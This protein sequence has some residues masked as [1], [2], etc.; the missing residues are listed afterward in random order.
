MEKSLVGLW[1]ES[2][3]SSFNALINRKS[4]PNYTTDTIPQTIVV[5]MFNQYPSLGARE[6]GTAYTAPLSRARFSRIAHSTNDADWIDIAESDFWFDNYVGSKKVV[7]ASSDVYD[8]TVADGSPNMIVNGV[9][10]HNC[11]KK[12]KDVMAEMKD[13][14]INGASP[15]VE[16]G[17]ITTS[18]VEEIWMLIE[19]F[20]GYGFN[21][22]H[23][24]SYSAITCVELWMKYHYPVEYLT[25]LLNNTK[26]GKKK[27]NSKDDLLAVYINYARKRNIDVMGPSINRSSVEFATDGQIILFSLRHVKN[28]AKAADIIASGQP[29][30]DV[31]DFYERAAATGTSAKTGK[32]TVRKVNKEVVDSLISAGAFRDFGDRN[33]VSQQYYACRKKKGEVAPQFPESEWNKMEEEML[34]ICLS[35]VPL[36]RRF[37]KDIAEKK[38]CPIDEADERKRTKVFGRITSIVPR[39]SK[40][41]NQMYVVGLTDD[42]DNMTFF[43]FGG[44]MV[45]FKDNFKVGYVA[46]I[47][48]NRFED[49][50]TRYYDVD[51]DADI[52][53][54]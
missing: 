30:K 53:E 32:T 44:A 27:F 6:S 21:A 10:V 7:S 34:G 4:T 48:L 5:K 23:A 51:R 2:K 17:E 14:F 18:Q 13:R 35:T 12:K 3:R 11:G 24:Y 36:R 40:K 47:P 45:K 39:T 9:V 15:R 8:F 31:Q 38:W 37:Q 25:A 20:A 19:R 52:V 22:S 41:G 28:V 50:D 49:S 26:P 42:L 29:Y 1:P 46:A 33:T 43:V 54:K 16:A